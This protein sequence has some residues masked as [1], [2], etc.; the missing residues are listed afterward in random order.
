MFFVGEQVVERLLNLVVQKI[1]LPTP[2]T[3][4]LGTREPA[5]W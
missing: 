5:D 4:S 2:G 3:C 1:A